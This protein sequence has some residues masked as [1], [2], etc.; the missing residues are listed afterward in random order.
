MPMNMQAMQQR[1]DPDKDVKIFL[2]AFIFMTVSSV[3]GSQRGGP[4]RLVT[5]WSLPLGVTGQEGNLFNH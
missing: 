1:I 4:G 3:S 5:A 2:T